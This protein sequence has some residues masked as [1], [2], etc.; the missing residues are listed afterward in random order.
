MSPRSGDHAPRP[1]APSKITVPDVRSRKGGEKL[2]MLTAYDAPSARL[3][4]AAGADVILVGDSLGMVVLGHENTLAV[5]LDDMV[6]HTAAVARTRPRALVVADMPYLTYHTGPRDAVLAAGRL[7]REGGAEAVKLEGG[8]R[9]VPVIEALV[10]AEIPVVGHLG[11]TPQSLHVMGGFRV[12]ARALEAIDV[13]IDDAHALVGAGVFALV[14][15]GVPA[16]V[17]R[18]VT[19]EVPVPT[20]GIGAGEGCDGQV[21]VFHDVL[22]LSEGPTPRFVRRY[23]DL[24]AAAVE[25]LARFADDVRRGTFPAREETYRLPRRV[26]DALDE[27]RRRG[28]AGRS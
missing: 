9:R 23:A 3:V 20:I 25:A 2:V 18:L 7:V 10:D 17:A 1:A 15:E 4:D 12:Q 19:D 22:G 14:L 13:L 28:T 5:D 21:L 6:R 8:R 27:R 16:D 24:Q 26:A 11:L